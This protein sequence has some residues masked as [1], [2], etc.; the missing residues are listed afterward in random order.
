MVELILLLYGLCDAGDPWGA[1]LVEYLV[2]QPKMTPLKMDEAIFYWVGD[3][4]GNIFKITG[5]YA[6]DCLNA[7]NTEFQRQTQK[8]L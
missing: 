1:T 8:T 6:N 2:D 7:G 3:A 5:T 4:K